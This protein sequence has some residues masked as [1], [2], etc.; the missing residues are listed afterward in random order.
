MDAENNAKDK[1]SYLRRAA[2][3]MAAIAVAAATAGGVIEL[4]EKIAALF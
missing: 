1:S 3:A 4:C 2:K